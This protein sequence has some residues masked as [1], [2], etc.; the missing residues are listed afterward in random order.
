MQS[1]LRDRGQAIAFKRD[2]QAFV[3]Q[4]QHVNRFAFVVRRFI[5]RIV[6]DGQRQIKKPTDE[7][8]MLGGSRLHS[9]HMVV[10]VMVVIVVSG[11]VVVTWLMMIVVNVATFMRMPMARRRNTAQQ[12]GDR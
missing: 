10:V 12:H 4:P 8:D 1:N 6:V 11:N 9:A 3:N 7:M 5:I 2:R